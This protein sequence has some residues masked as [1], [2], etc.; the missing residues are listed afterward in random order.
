MKLRRKLKLNEYTENPPLRRSSYL[1]DDEG[2]IPQIDGN[3]TTNVGK[4]K[5]ADIVPEM[6]G[7]E[8]EEDKENTPAADTVVDTVCSRLS[9]L[10][11]K[12]KL[13]IRTSISESLFNTT[14]ESP[15]DT[16]V[17]SINESK[18]LQELE[19][20]LSSKK[21]LFTD[22]VED[23]LQSDEEI[24][25]SIKL[26]PAVAANMDVSMDSDE[27]ISVLDSDEE[28]QESNLGQPPI[29]TTS[30]SF[31]NCSTSMQT[32][33][34]F[35]NNPPSVPSKQA[36]VTHS[37]IQKFK[38]RE[39]VEMEA[40]EEIINNSMHESEKELDDTV[41]DHEDIEI[42]PTDESDNVIDLT[43]DDNSPAPKDKCERNSLH[44][45]IKSVSTPI[46]ITVGTQT[47]TETTQKKK[48]FANINIKFDLK[49]SIRERSA[50]SEET[51][52][53][54]T[55]SSESSNLSVKESHLKALPQSP[56][57]ERKSSAK[58][59]PPEPKHSESDDMVPVRD[60]DA[61][62]SPRKPV[63]DKQMQLML[64]E[65]YSD[66]WKTPEVL[67]KFDIR[68]SIAANNFESCKKLFLYQ[69]IA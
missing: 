3:N 66:A 27:V 13:P 67:K 1:T 33:D 59:M 51:D 37:L 5:L 6:H 64:D 31:V 22:T 46:S 53:N 48:N 39:L 14:Q 8:D 2:P 61:Y 25:S 42:G 43:R 9:E 34:D 63:I 16:V 41:S 68:K 45:R 50:T 12:P 26:E 11:L 54:S 7:N 29:V 17:D 58:T 23:L 30:D 24:D 21:K 44:D 65:M 40:V 49:I 38:N 36:V 55:V 35:F 28:E 10:Q 69:S 4:E 15:K 19:V 62:Q 60:C 47:P 57:F 52:T 56:I 20:R 18:V 32:L